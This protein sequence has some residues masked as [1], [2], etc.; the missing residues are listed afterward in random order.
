MEPAQHGLAGFFASA[1]RR[2]PSLSKVADFQPK[3]ASSKFLKG[4]RA[5]HGRYRSPGGL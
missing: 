5:K 3:V 1:P 4:E 2:F